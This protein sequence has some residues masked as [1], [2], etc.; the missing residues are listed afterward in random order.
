MSLGFGSMDL[1]A[2]SN[3]R[4]VTTTGSNLTN[5]GFAAAGAWPAASPMHRFYLFSTAVSYACVPDAAGTG[6]LTRYGG[7][8]L[9][10]SQPALT[11]AAPLST[12]ASALV[13]NKDSACSFVRGT[14]QADVNAMQ[15]NLQLARAGE[16]VTL[17]AQVNAPNGP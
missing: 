6:T 3:V 4:A 16:T 14:S 10:A 8:A 13:V 15:I 17:Y 2:G 11:T 5:L 9:Q 12:A 1:Y 7:Y